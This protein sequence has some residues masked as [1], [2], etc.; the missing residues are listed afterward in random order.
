MK[1]TPEET[2]RSCGRSAAAYDTVQ[3]S[4]QHGS[5]TLCGQCF[6]RRA[7]ARMGFEFTHPVFD[8]VTVMDALGASHRFHFRAHL[9]PGGLLVEGFEL[10]GGYP[11]GHTFAVLGESDDD[12]LELFRELLMRIRRG[13]ARRHLRVGMHGREIGDERT[14][15]GRVSWDD[16]P[17]G[18]LPMLI[19]DGEEVTWEDSDGC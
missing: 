13:L 11:G 9:A 8:S 14:I 16:E 2:C 1:S 3:T 4:G 17:D 18:R 15:R 5:E 10:K 7:A 19:I 6:N 12:P